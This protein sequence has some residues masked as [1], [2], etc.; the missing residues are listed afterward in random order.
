MQWVADALGALPEEVATAADRQRLLGV[1]TSVA[2]EGLGVDNERALYEALG[3]FS[4]LCRRNRRV[5]GAAQRA[6]LPP[7]LHGIVV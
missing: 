3:E 5:Q 2:G 1:A 4:E 7:E 6:L